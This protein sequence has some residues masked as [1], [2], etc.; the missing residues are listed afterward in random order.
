MIEVVDF[1][2]FLRA[3]VSAHGAEKAAPFVAGFFGEV[4]VSFAGLSWPAQR[5][6][7]SN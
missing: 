3:I 2:P 5:R 4:A 7:L 1:V 6:A